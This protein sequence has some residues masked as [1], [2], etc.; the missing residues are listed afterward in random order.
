MSMRVQ[1]RVQYRVCARTRHDLQ[2]PDLS[3]LSLDKPHPNGIPTPN[4]GVDG[5]DTFGRPS[6]FL[7]PNHL[8]CHISDGRATETDIQVSE[9]QPVVSL[10]GTTTYRYRYQEPDRDDRNAMGSYVESFGFGQLGL[11]KFKKED[12]DFGVEFMNPPLAVNPT[13]QWQTRTQGQDDDYNSDDALYN[14]VHQALVHVPNTQPYSDIDHFTWKFFGKAAPSSNDPRFDDIKHDLL[15]SNGVQ[16]GSIL[17]HSNLYLLEVSLSMT[18][19]Q[20]SLRLRKLLYDAF[21]NQESYFMMSTMV[22]DPQAPNVAAYQ[23]DGRDVSGHISHI[24]VALTFGEGATE[25]SHPISPDAMLLDE[26]L[27]EL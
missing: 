2:L 24:E 16:D 3:T 25:E 12:F 15:P 20:R 17:F 14:A 11:G 1:D 9:V 13:N 19:D 4:I 5:F 6:F 8:K 10:N 27:D 18:L 21:P 26:L 22:H 23:I 7:P